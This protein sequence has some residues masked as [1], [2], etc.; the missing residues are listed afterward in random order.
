MVVVGIILMVLGLGFITLA[1]IHS[2][3]EA[4]TLGVISL[5]IGIGIFSFNTNS[6]PI[7]SEK[8]RKQELLKELNEVKKNKSLY[9]LRKE[10]DKLEDSIYKLKNGL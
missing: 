7:Q 6:S 10:N 3:F 1:I 5:M 2:D 9:E 4:F 8:E